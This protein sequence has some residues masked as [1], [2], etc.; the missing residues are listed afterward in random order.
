MTDSPVKVSWFFGWRFF[1]PQ[2]AFSG[3]AFRIGRSS[4]KMFLA[5]YLAFNLVS[6][7]SQ[8]Q[9]EEKCITLPETNITHENDGFQ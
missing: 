5:E 8:A 1:H 7:F 4:P 6:R 9:P 2:E 3:V